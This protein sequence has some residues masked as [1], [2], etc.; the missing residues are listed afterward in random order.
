[1]LEKIKKVNF[2]TKDKTKTFTEENNLKHQRNYHK[3]NRKWEI[4]IIN[5][6]E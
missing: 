1:M 6:S 3:I 5:W 4:R 2:E